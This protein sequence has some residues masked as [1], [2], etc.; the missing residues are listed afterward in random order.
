MSKIY[1]LF[2]A[3]VLAFGSATSQTGRSYKIFG[4]KYQQV[5]ITSDELAGAVYFRNRGMGV[6]IPG[7]WA[8]MEKTVCVRMNTPTT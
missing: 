1:I 2:I 3:A 8:N 5:T 6:P 4:P 7:R